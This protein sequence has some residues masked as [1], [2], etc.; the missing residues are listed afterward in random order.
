MQHARTTLN[1]VHIMHLWSLERAIVHR[2]W[3]CL[4][5]HTHTRTV[6]MEWRQLA[7]M[8]LWL[9]NLLICPCARFN[10]HVCVC[11]SQ[12]PF[13]W[14][15]SVQANEWTSEQICGTCSQWRCEL[16]FRERSK[17]PNGTR[18]KTKKTNRKP[19]RRYKAIK[20][21]ELNGLYDDDSKV[22]FIPFIWFIGFHATN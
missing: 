2:P 13:R 21:T 1:H 15:M 7:Y 8:E 9:S 6:A 19:A 12:Q 11:C 22:K 20:Q 17:T 18:K 14:N 5:V 10:V 16:L 4:Q 3:I